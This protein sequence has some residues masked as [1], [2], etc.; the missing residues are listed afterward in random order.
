[1]E[2]Q[3]KP[4]SKLEQIFESRPVRITF[5]LCSIFLAYVFASWA[6]DSGSLLDYVIAFLFLV[7]GARELIEGFFK[8]RKHQ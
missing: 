5:G 2:K 3:A 4:K 7:V 1:M 8:K 6:I